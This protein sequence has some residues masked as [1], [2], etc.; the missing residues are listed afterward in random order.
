MTYC[1]PGCDSGRTEHILDGMCGSSPVVSG[2]H[3]LALVPLRTQTWTVSLCIL[4]D[5]LLN[6]WHLGA[7]LWVGW[8]DVFTFPES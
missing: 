6:P 5:A 3:H 4:A 8:E 1:S 7:T 2:R